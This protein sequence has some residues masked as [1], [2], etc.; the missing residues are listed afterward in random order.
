MSTH[1]WRRQ[2]WFPVP[3]YREFPNGNDEPQQ[4][5]AAERLFRQPRPTKGW[6][7]RGSR[8]LLGAGGNLAPRCRAL[9][10]A[11]PERH[12]RAGRRPHGARALDG[13]R[14]S[15]RDDLA[16]QRAQRRHPAAHRVRDPQPEAAGCGSK[17][18]AAQ[19]PPAKRAAAGSDPAG[20]ATVAP[21]PSYP[22]GIAPSDVHR[23]PALPKIAAPGPHACRLHP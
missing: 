18:Q 5:A 2:H 3:E 11:V 12:A 17:S 7:V 20:P 6:H 15:E 10:R 8:R 23:L 16:D 21:W 13:Q 14:G 1:F 22:Q 9:E 19:E 4:A